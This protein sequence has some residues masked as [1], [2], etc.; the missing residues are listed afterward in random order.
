[1]AI[2]GN[3]IKTAIEIS[4]R[5]VPDSEGVSAQE[6]QLRKLLKTAKNTEFGKR[7][8]FDKL[9]RAPDIFRA[10]AE[11]VPIHDY[12]KIYDEWW[13]RLVDN[14]SDITWP[15][16]PRYFAL[17][18]GTTGS[19][20]KR[21]PVTDEM[22]AA[23]RNT[24][25]Q[26][27]RGLANFDLPAEFFEKEIM[28]LGSSTDLKQRGNY[29]EGEI[30]GI[31][32]SNIP[33]WFKGFYKPGDD[34]AQIDDWDERVQKIAEKAEEWDIGALSGI[35]SWIE[36]MLKKVI[37]YH[38]L[39]NIHDIWPNLMVYTPGGVAFEPYRKSFEKLLAHPL[40]YLDTY[41]A[42][43]GFLAYQNRPDTTSMA[44]SVDNGIF[45]EFVPFEEGNLTETGSVKDGAKVL[46]L[47]EVEEHKDYVLIISTV[48]GAW[49]YMIGDTVMFTDKSRNEI[50]IT[51]RTK[52]F[53][54]VVGSQLSVHKMN[55]AMR[56]LEEEFNI[57][58]PEFTVAA[59]R[60]E[61]DQEYI[62]KWYLGTEGT[63]DADKAAQSLDEILSSM[64]KN[65]RVARSKALKDIKVETVPVDIFYQWSERN[66][67]KGGQMK[68]P[69]VMD[70]EKFAEW[71]A[72]TQEAQV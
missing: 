19:S 11:N 47:A 31:S 35:P 60:R 21:I 43:E 62:H 41:L 5:L 37:D 39:N 45:F 10:Y 12:Q 67:K 36:L 57:T 42:S 8:S 17:S 48:A 40:V 1:M 23:I 68:T 55:E 4:D 59:V 13:Y 51:G 50:R 6:L 54:N 3:I 26:Q 2:L 58:I 53:L 18:S 71:E 64:N 24:G 28:M 61:S 66:K 33:F 65:Y 52:H 69:R 34:I 63:L 49:R 32:A 22:L 27:V 29:L 7:Y 30:S 25:I 46:T 72:F 38:K 16:R 15:G 14:E 20:S 56:K 44:L 70:E 9:L